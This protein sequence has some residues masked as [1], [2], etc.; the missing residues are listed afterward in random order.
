MT[1]QAL[2]EK[3]AADADLRKVLLLPDSLMSHHSARQ[4]LAT[5]K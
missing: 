5:I 4:S 1:E 2:S 3:A